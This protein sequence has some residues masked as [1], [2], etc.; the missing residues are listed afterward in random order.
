M[1]KRAI[2]VDIDD[3]LADNAAGA[4]IRALLFGEYAWNASDE[5]LPQGVD[6]AKDWPAVA[7]YFQSLIKEEAA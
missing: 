7:E 5:V 4:G 1:R 6:R 2:A 3:V